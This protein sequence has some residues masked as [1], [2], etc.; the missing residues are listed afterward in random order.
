[1]ETVFP[2]LQMAYMAVNVTFGVIRL[3]KMFKK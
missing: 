1:M 2:Y 3:Y